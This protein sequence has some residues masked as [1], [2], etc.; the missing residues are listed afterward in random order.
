VC[1]VLFIMCSRDLNN[2]SLRFSSINVNSMNVST[3]GSRNAKTYIKIEG[4]TGKKADVIFLCDVRANNKGADLEKLFRMTRNGNYCLYLN[5]TKNARGVGIA[6]RRAIAHEVKNVIKDLRNENYILLDIEIKGKRFTMGSIYG[7]NENNVN[8]Y[9]ELKAKLGDFGTNKFI[10]GGDF[11]TILDMDR[12]ADNLD[13]MGAG[14]IPNKVNGEFIN[15]WIE[16]GGS[17]NLLELYIRR[18]GRFPMFP[19]GV[20]LGLMMHGN[21]V[22]L[23]WIFTL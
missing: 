13:R 16:E 19:I 22:N 15:G 12:T 23:G 8:F 14:R 7:P 5:W 21:L 10:I 2:L 20:W 3:L 4:V 18:R 17:L 11:N 6:I 1:G 9:R